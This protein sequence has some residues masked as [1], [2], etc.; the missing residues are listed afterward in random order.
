[1]IGTQLKVTT[2]A[3]ASDVDVS[4]LLRAQEEMAGFIGDVSED[5]RFE[6]YYK[7]IVDSNNIEWQNFK[8]LLAVI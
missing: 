8:A 7:N 1:M 3:K 6:E 5:H 2:T 4:S